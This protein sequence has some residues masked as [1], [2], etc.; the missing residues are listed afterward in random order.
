MWTDLVQAYE[1]KLAVLEEA[2]AAYSNAIT[3]V[4][5]HAGPAMEAAVREGIGDV[6]AQYL[7]EAAILES[8]EN[9]S[10][11]HAPWS[12][13]TMVDVVAGT[14]FRIAAWIASSWGGPEGVLRVGLSLANV[15]S[16]LDLKGWA[17]K[18]GESL[19]D[20]V[21]GEPSAPLDWQ[22]FPDTPPDWL[23]IRIASVELVNRDF[24]Q[25]AKDASD[26]ARV[27]ARSVV[28]MLESIRDAGIPMS[29]VEDALLR[30]RPSLEA[31][32]AQARQ[33]VTPAKGLGGPW[34]GGKYLQ[35]GSFW[36]ASHPAANDLLAVAHRKDE[37]I[38]SN[39]GEQLSRPT[40]R[41]GGNLSVVL[42]DEKQLRD[43]TFDIGRA[44][45]AAFDAWF[46]AKARGLS[47][48]SEGELA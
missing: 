18:C 42:L 26:A 19:V 1:S 9:A 39:L 7:V 46:D 27:F 5:D 21:P 33:Q 6:A 48:S 35:V 30:Y 17:A 40:S 43:P 22:K 45:A 23:T 34:Q 2:R 24:R 13:I 11:A 16:G 41:R 8:G 20:M 38:I 14:E 31:R 32:A 10:F 44:I 28:P 4:I 3:T 15:R 12:C 37:E 36:L 47:A 25:A 29:L